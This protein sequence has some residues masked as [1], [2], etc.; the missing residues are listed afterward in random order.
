MMLLSKNV[1][2]ALALTL[3]SS[4]HVSAFTSP[5]QS[6]LMKKYSSK[7]QH[8]MVATTPDALINGNTNEKSSWD[9][10][11]EINCVE[12]PAC[13]ED[14][15]RT[16]LDVRIA[17][18]WYDLSGWRKGHPAGSHWIDWYDGRDAT[19][20]MDAFHSIKGRKMYQRLPKSESDTVKILENSVAKDTP[21]MLAFRELR[22]QL[23]DDGWFDR[24]LKREFTLLGIWGSM[25][26]GA[27]ATAHTVP[28]LSIFL[29]ALTMTQAGW[30]GH[31]YVHGVDKW[32]D[33]MRQFTTVAGGLGCTWWSDKHNKHHA[34]TNEQGV[35]EDIAT[36]PFL[37]TW[38]PD[39]KYD[40]P[41]RKI[42]HLIFFYS[43]LSTFRTL[44]SGYNQSHCGSS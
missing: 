14:E 8:H 1:K 33:R 18:T 6:S 12:V 41:L 11:E 22:Q 42:Q 30:L 31:D 37:Y 28:F 34:L 43:L 32:C 10:D 39:P 17:G 26:A 15:C 13:K 7:T 21:T 27:I 23:E 40:S 2:L 5:M 24:D 9:C 3:I 38:A 19:E 35:D 20:V 4:N 25:F 29:L 36:D 44:A 16:S